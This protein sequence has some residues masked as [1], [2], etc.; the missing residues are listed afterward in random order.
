MATKLDREVAFDEKM[1][2][3]KSHNLSITCT[4]QVKKRIIKN[5]IFSIPR[6]LRPPNL[7]GSGLMLRSHKL[8]SYIFFQS[9]GHVRLL[10]RPMT[11]KLDMVMAF[12][13]GLPLTFFTL[14]QRRDE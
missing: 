2:F 8:Q 5:V 14:Q 9:R 4:H 6:D 13:K 11:T 12:E 1:L 10:A 3:T 7:T